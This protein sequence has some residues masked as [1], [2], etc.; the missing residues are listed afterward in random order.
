MRAN[1]EYSARIRSVRMEASRTA[2]LVE[3][4][5]LRVAVE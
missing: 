4:R 1:P 3:E 2:N 5:I